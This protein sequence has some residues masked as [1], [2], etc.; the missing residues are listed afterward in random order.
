MS[1]SPDIH[2]KNRTRKTYANVLSCKL[3][4][5]MIRVHVIKVVGTQHGLDLQYL[6]EPYCAA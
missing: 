6:L 3:N 1:P 4:F 5:C 2:E